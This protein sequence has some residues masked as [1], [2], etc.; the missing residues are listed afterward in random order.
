[1]T[2]GYASEEIKL[3]K[4]QN[5]EFWTNKKVRI[6]GTLIDIGS[7]YFS[8]NV[9]SEEQLFAFSEVALLCGFEIGKAPIK[10]GKVTK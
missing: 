8:V 6:S 10:R 1:M 4:G 2:K 3:R 5:I 9:D 7:Y